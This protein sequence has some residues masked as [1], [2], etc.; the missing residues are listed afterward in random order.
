MTVRFAGRLGVVLAV[1]AFG[2]AFSADAMPV[3]GKVTDWMG[4]PLP[5]RTVYIDAHRYEQRVDGY[6]GQD[7]RGWDY[8]TCDE[9]F[10]FTGSTI[11]NASGDFA[12]NV[13]LPEPPPDPP[14]QQYSCDYYPNGSQNC[15]EPSVF[16]TG[17]TLTTSGANYADS[18]WCATTATCNGLVLRAPTVQGGSTA[19][20]SHRIGLPGAAPA[21]ASGGKRGAVVFIGGFDPGGTS[22]PGFYRDVL[23]RTMMGN[24]QNFL[25]FVASLG[26]ELWLELPGKNSSGDLTTIAADLKS[27]L[28]AIANMGGNTTCTPLPGFPVPSP[29][30]H[31]TKLVVLGYS[32]GGIQGKLVV[33]QM[34]PTV[35]PNCPVKLFGALDAPLAG[36]SVPYALMM[37]LRDPNLAQVLANAGASFGAAEVLKA[38]A[39]AQM[40]PAVPNAGCYTG[41]INWHGDLAGFTFDSCNSDD[42][43]FGSYR[44]PV[45]PNPFID[46]QYWIYAWAP[47]W[48]C[49]PNTSQFDAYQTAM[50]GVPA[51][52]SIAF[53][54]GK[55]DPYTFTDDD[56]PEFTATDWQQ[57]LFLKQHSWSW[58]NL[59]VPEAHVYL[60]LIGDGRPFPADHAGGGSM[61]NIWDEAKP[62][63]LEGHYQV[64]GAAVSMDIDVEHSFHFIPWESAL[65]GKDDGAWIDWGDNTV[66][67]DHQPRIFNAGAPNNFQSTGLPTHLASMVGAHILDRMSGDGD[68]QPVCLPDVP[69]FLQPIHADCEPPSG[70]IEGDCVDND[71]DGGVDEGL[72]PWPWPPKEK[73]LECLDERCAQQAATCLDER[74]TNVCADAICSVVT[75]AS[76]SCDGVEAGCNAVRSARRG[77]TKV[78]YTGR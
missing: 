59:V 25:Q 36:A 18:K 29:Q 7:G 56:N 72:V 32:Q 8:Y 45:N 21:G 70:E 11:T 3:S 38:P 37:M 75:A 15:T 57:M 44:Y 2:L 49:L 76:I 60:R 1:A 43:S 41:C 5:N 13:A 34:C 52:P 12:T 64:Q 62:V 48:G 27:D 4:T 6:M 55:D 61:F 68:G 63:G 74:C 77:A 31:P 51:V 50:G 24:G 35:G 20:D 10:S 19:Y 66:N 16:D 17:M 42:D 30:V 73:A 14:C 67:A 69:T 54:M 33:N 47:H 46:P 23:S 22:G 78:T 58:A 39:V 28:Y 65:E 53:S 71:G 9:V 40:L 26:L